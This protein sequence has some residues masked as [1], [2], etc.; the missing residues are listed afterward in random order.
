M[1]RLSLPRWRSR[2]RLYVAGLAALVVAL[3][4]GGAALAGSLSTSSPLVLFYGNSQGFES[5]TYLSALV[6]LTTGAKVSTRA[7]GGTNVCDWFHTM[8]DDAT[9][10]PAAV[11]IQ[12]GKN[13]FTR[14]MDDR[15]GRPVTG[16]RLDEKV[17]SDIKTAMG[18]FAGAPHIFLAGYPKSRGDGPGWDY[19]NH[20]VASLARPGVTF[21][22]AGAAVEGP[23]GTYTQSL[24]CLT[25]EPCADDPG[26][27][28]NVV[29]AP[30]GVHF[31]P[32]G[33]P[34]NSPTTA[35]CPVYSSGAFRY[36]L[37]MAGPVESSLLRR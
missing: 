20:L 21:V 10:N 28:L 36:A 6:T 11:V 35:V 37:A 30:D 5:S 31:C 15:A 29:R 4:L 3:G 14:C 7:A 27:G 19:L 13:N 23:D 1:S 16:V 17:Y 12:F 33:Y 22:N 24:P 8:S 32:V 26:P 2:R 34:R 9:L 18:M 25:F